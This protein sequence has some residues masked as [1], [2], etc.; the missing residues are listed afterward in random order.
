MLAGKLGL[1]STFHVFAISTTQCASKQDRISPK[2]NVTAF[3]FRGGD[4]PNR[5][6]LRNQREFEQG[7]QV[8]NL[9]LTFQ[10]AVDFARLMGRQYLWIA[11][12]CIIQDT[13]DDWLRESHTMS[14]IYS[15]AWLNLAATSSRD[16]S[17]RTVLS[18]EV[19]FINSSRR[20]SLGRWI[21]HQT[22]RY[23]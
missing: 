4:L 19:L 8:D 11:A 16:G 3:C 21:S 20:L 9:P 10:H 6:L 7:I 15:S 22:I 23:Q 13:R 12:L 18:L 5:L 2:T 14:S 17:G 1:R